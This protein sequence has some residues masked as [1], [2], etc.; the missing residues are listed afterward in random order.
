MCLKRKPLVNQV[1]L[2]KELEIVKSRVL[3]N[4][5]MNQQVVVDDAGMFKFR[6]INKL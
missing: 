5:I 3:I 2:K 6:E 4:K 1:T